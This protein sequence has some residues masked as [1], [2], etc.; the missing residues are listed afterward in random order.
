MLIWASY[1]LE[2]KV[3]QMAFKFNIWD[4]PINKEQQDWLFNLIYGNKEV[5]HSTMKI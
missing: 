1:N 3:Q 4:A 2:D 5:S